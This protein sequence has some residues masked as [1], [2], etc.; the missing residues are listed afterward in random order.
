MH[1]FS[2]RLHLEGE[3]NAAQHWGKQHHLEINATASPRW[4]TFP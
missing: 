2:E 3:I 4:R 1:G